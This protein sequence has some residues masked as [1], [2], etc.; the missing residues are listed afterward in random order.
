M[1]MNCYFKVGYGVAATGDVPEA[2]VALMEDDCEAQVAPGIRAFSGY[3]EGTG[4]EEWSILIERTS[5]RC[6]HRGEIYSRGGSSSAVGI[7][8]L[9]S[10][11]WAELEALA[12]VLNTLGIEL[13]P[14]QLFLVEVM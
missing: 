13:T 12:E 1:S 2:L 6:D 4:E 3:N 11:T 14:G 7:T 8:K 9:E 10:P 5:V